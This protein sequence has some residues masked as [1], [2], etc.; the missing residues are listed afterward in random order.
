MNGPLLTVVIPI[1]NAEK[2]IKDV[3]A[4]VISQTYKS[5]ELI[6]VDDGSTDKSAKICDEY[7]SKYSF[8]KVIH[9]ANGGVHTARNTGLEAATGEYICFIDSDDWINEDY[10]EL[11]MNAILITNSDFAACGFITEYAEDKVSTKKINNK[12][13]IITFSTSTE[14]TS[15]IGN[16]KYSVGGFVWNKIFKVSTIGNLRFRDDIQIFYHL[17]NKY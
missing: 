13:N 16:G 3:V 10:C 6:L 11:L 15:A 14:C 17:F 2:Y 12:P 7:Q 5:I 9:K 8:I 4:C 1:Y